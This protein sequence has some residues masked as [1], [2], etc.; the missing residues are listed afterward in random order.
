MAHFLDA[1]AFCF[2]HRS[3]CAA[4]IFARAAADIVRRP[5]RPDPLGRPGPRFATLRLPAGRPR[6]MMRSAASAA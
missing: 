5:P 3:F 1:A 2:A 6:R 4:E